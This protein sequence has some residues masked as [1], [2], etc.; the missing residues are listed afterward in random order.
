M[1]SIT[2]LDKGSGSWQL[3]YDAQTNSNKASIGGNV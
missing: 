3:I 1:I 2:Y